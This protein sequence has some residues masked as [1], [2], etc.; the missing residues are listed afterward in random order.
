MMVLLA[1]CG[2]NWIPQIAEKLELP[3]DK[4]PRKEILGFIEKQEVQSN[5]C[6]TKLLSFFGQFLASLELGDLLS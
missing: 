2:L 1:N 6:S 5:F 3:V 4:Y